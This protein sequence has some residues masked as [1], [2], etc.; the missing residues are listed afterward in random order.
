M[1]P[2]KLSR[3]DRQ[4]RDVAE[5]RR[6]SLSKCVKCEICRAESDVAKLCLVPVHRYTELTRDWIMLRTVIFV[7]FQFA[8]PVFFSLFCRR[9]ILC[10]CVYYVLLMYVVSYCE[11][12]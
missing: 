12:V 7:S 11:V 10:N 1:C 4:V 5:L 8:G 9:V 2:W 6:R 3:S